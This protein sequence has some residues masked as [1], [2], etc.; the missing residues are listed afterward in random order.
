MEASTNKTTKYLPVISIIAFVVFYLLYRNYGNVE[1][2]FSSTPLLSFVV[3]MG[4]FT[5]VVAAILSL[6]FWWGKV[7]YMVMKGSTAHISKFGLY[8]G[9]MLT[10]LII[11]IYVRAYL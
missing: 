5:L 9:F 8:V 1:E 11:V 3:T 4:L 10:A 2:N 6:V 7:L